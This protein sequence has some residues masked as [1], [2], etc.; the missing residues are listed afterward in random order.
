MDTK[1]ECPVCQREIDINCVSVSIEYNFEHWE[2]DGLFGGKPESGD[3]LVSKT[4]TGKYECLCGAN[5]SIHFNGADVNNV[6][7]MI[8]YVITGVSTNAHPA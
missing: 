7:N 2:Y 1:K 8:D 6:V 3:T 4:A 5:I